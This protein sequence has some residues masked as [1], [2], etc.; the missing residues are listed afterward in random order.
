MQQK[1][2]ESDLAVAHKALDQI[3]TILEKLKLRPMKLYQAIDLGARIRTL[4]KNAEVLD[5]G[6]KAE[7]KA[8]LKN[9][10]GSLN[11]EVMKA[12]VSEVPN[13]KF[14]ITAF[15]EKHAALASQYTVS[16]P[17]LKV[18]YKPR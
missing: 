9:K 4:I 7:I 5:D 12:V 17:T 16:K 3:N 8:E 6:I 11:G 2:S 15:R 1:S 14:D 18:E 13:N 10:P